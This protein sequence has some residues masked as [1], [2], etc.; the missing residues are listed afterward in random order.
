MVDRVRLVREP[1][2]VFAVSLL[3]VPKRQRPENNESGVKAILPLFN[4]I[5]FIEIT[6]KEPFF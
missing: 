4:S 3:S 2:F 6:P 1:S 5:K